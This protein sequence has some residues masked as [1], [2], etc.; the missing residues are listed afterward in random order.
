MFF[1]ARKVQFRLHNPAVNNSQK[2]RKKMKT[3]DQSR[4]E[5]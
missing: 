3:I 4:M 1:G 2:S 5:L